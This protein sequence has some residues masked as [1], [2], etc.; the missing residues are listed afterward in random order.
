[1]KY[2]L[3][4]ATLLDGTAAMEPR[5]NMTVWIDGEKITSIEENGAAMPDSEILD[6]Q[7]AYLMP[8]LVNMHVHLPVAGNPPK[9]DKKINYK[10]LATLLSLSVVRR[11]FLKSQQKY[12]RDEL[13]S[14]VTTL[15]AVGGLFDFDAQ[16]RD[17]VNDGTIPGPRI[18]T[19]NTAISVP[20]GHF[21]GSLATEAISPEMAR[22]HVQMIAATRPDLIKLMITGGVMD[23]TEEGEPGALRMPPELVRAACEEA[24]A[25]G[26]KVAAHVESVEGVTVALQNG[27]DTIEHGAKPND[28][29]LRLF[30]ERNA[31]FI[32]TVSPAIPYTFFDLSVSRCG[33]IGRKNGRVIFEAGIECGKACLQNGIPV[34][35][36]TDTG[37]PF[38]THYNMWRE[39]HYFAK[40]M[41]VSPAFALH[42]ATLGNARIAGLGDVTG[43][44][45]V[46]KCA[47]LIVSAGNPLESFA[48]LQKLEYVF[49]RGRIV[50]HPK[51]KKNPAVDTEL[52]KFM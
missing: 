42:T 5:P 41:E 2:T 16:I 29:I 18:L 36:G 37:C 43:S 46:G 4:N 20:G 39:V 30:K 9:T 6:L 27:V 33:E 25:L 34:G 13:Y 28:E 31:V 21:A 48:N 52:D 26:F 8:G 17:L 15:R 40:Y 23:A 35:M 10:D 47:D 51:I 45:E 3:K 19:A 14:G 49:A 7:G 32:S 22:E 12:V 11:Y 50:R 38:I 24:H 44:V 1:M